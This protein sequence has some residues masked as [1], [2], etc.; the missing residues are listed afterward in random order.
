MQ[1]LMMKDLLNNFCICP[2]CKK[3]KLQINYNGQ[4]Y[5]VFCKENYPIIYGIPIL[6]T[7]I[8]CRKLNLNYYDENIEKKLLKNKDFKLNK[9]KIIN[10][11]KKLLPLTSGFLY[12]NINKLQK[13]PIG[14][15][16]FKKINKK[17]DLKLLDVGCGWGRWTLNAGQKNYKCLGIDISIKSLIIAKKISQ[18][19][20]LKNCNFICCDVLDMPLKKNIFD[21]VYSYSFL[22]HFSEK[23][24]KI[25]LTQIANKMKP[26]AEFKTQMINKYGLRSIYNIFRIKFCRQKMIKKKII[27]NGDKSENFNVRYFSISKINKIF[28]NL[29]FIKEIKNN[30]FF[31]QA[32]IYDFTILKGKYKFFLIISF[33]FNLMAKYIIFMKYFSD[34]LMYSLKKRDF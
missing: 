26:N 7:K 6:I 5:C 19:L 27:D 9:F 23:N 22:Q 32:L 20:N 2:N 4:I 31:T 21:R 11:F 25:I 14:D 24:L 17:I 1:S 12:L 28:S 18:Q 8:K 30:S 33:M 29:F 13:Y 16:P 15:I 34:N 3:N 10:C